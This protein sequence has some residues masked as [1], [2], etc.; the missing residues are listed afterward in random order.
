MR[1]EGYYITRAVICR[2]YWSIVLGFLHT[3]YLEKSQTAELTVLLVGKSP[4]AEGKALR[5]RSLLFWLER[6]QCLLPPP[7]K[8]PTPGFW[9]TS[10][11][12]QVKLWLT[13]F[14]LMISIRVGGK[15]FANQIICPLYSASQ[16]YVTNIPH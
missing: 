15:M 13:H 10:C 3:G 4:S 6:F 9:D 1:D 7:P 11:P 12:K 2:E 16:P 5:S 14:P 8:P